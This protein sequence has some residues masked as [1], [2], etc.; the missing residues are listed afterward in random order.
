ML[1]E[2]GSASSRLTSME[3]LHSTTTQEKL[4]FK[5]AVFWNKEV[6]KSWIPLP[7]WKT[8]SPWGGTS[9]VE[10][11]QEPH[12]SKDKMT[13]LIGIYWIKVSHFSTYVKRSW[14]TWASSNVCKRFDKCVCSGEFKIRVDYGILNVALQRG[15][16]VSL[17]SRRS[18]KKVVQEQLRR[19]QQQSVLLS[20]VP[21]RYLEQ[22]SRPKQ[23]VLTEERRKSSHSSFDSK[24]DSSQ[25]AER[26]PHK[27]T[28]R[29]EV[30]VW[31]RNQS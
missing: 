25:E 20:L 28:K 24:F 6:Y 12:H 2:S 27:T 16:S 4:T 15:G 5:I 26:A 18:C 11:L 29:Q 3:V 19:F 21:S 8:E 7:Q 23:R 13:C 9:C 1:L 14:K 22:L 17:S 30:Q 31:E 10:F